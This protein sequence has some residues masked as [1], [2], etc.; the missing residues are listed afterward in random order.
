M[1]QDD[2]VM[3]NYTVAKARGSIKLDAEVVGVTCKEVN[4]YKYKLLACTYH[5]G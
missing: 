2:D 1:K 3:H 5:C 4:G